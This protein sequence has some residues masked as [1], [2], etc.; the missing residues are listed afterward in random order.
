MPAFFYEWPKFCPL[1][2]NCEM[3]PLPNFSSK[4]GELN[5]KVNGPEIDTICAVHSVVAPEI[6]VPVVMRKTK[7]KTKT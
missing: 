4:S 1:L 5:L 2:E 3:T 6:A 7:T